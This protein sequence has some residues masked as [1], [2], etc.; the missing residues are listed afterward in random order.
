MD[1]K[2]DS[3]ILVTGATGQIGGVGRTVVQMLRNRGLPVRAL[4]RTDDERAAALRAIGAEVVLGDLMNPCD[5]V[6]AMAN[7]RRLYFGLS[8]SPIYL[9]ATA[10]AAAAAREHGG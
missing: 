6:R 4:V 5:V 7:C 8:V 3:P 2:G 10:I 9:E 1:P